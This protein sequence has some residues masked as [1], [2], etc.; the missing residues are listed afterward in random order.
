MTL[1]FRAQLIQ[2]RWRLYRFNKNPNVGPVWTLSSSS[3]KQKIRPKK[4]LTPIERNCLKFILKTKFFVSRHHFEQA[5]KPYDVKDVLEQ[6]SAGHLDVL[7]RIKHI[8]HKI[9]RVESMAQSCLRG[10][11]ESKSLISYRLAKLEDFMKEM[12]SKVNQLLKIQ[13]ESQVLYE[14][15]SSVFENNSNP[16]LKYTETTA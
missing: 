6:Y 1:L 8:N 5:L 13:N 7:T 10:Q 15:I 2:S 14:N 16:C 12:D 11:H 9:S 4:I 3:P